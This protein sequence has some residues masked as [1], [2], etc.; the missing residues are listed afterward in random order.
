MANES[1][2]EQSDAVLLPQEVA[3][4][5]EGGGWLR[6]CGVWC[7]SMQSALYG[8]KGQ[9][10]SYLLDKECRWRIGC[11]CSCWTR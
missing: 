8:D 3:T 5:E 4:E 2:L 11:T 9:I 7:R 10:N 6:R 1:W